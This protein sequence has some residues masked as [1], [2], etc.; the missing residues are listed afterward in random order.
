MIL[1]LLFILVFYALKPSQMKKF[2]LCL[3]FVSICFSV[4]AQ[5]FFRLELDLFQQVESNNGGTPSLIKLPHRNATIIMGG[6]NNGEALNN[7]FNI[8]GTKII[9]DSI[10]QGADGHENV[11]LRRE[12]GR[13]FFDIFPTLS[14][15]LVPAE[16]P[17][18]EGT[19]TT[20]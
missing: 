6:L 8:Y 4:S 7:Y 13:N 15:T 14:A 1:L 17:I 16:H 2:F 20:N 19:D 3:L 10:N 5:E 18:N 11:V 9:I 12:D